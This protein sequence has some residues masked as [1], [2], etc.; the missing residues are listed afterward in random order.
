MP[1]SWSQLK[2]LRFCGLVGGL[3][4]QPYEFRAASDRARKHQARAWGLGLRSADVLLGGRR[5]STESTTAD[6]LRRRPWNAQVPLVEGSATL[7]AYEQWEQRLGPLGIQVPEAVQAGYKQ[8]QKE[9]AVR[10]SF[11]E[12]VS[13]DKPADAD[14]L[15]GFLAYLKLEEVRLPTLQSS[16]ASTISMRRY[17]Y[18]HV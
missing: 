18:F 14:K 15:A 13:P 9:V 11:E 3:V 7:R 5:L 2:P 10:A 4:M 16:L 12:A 17:S 1:F 8:A 6:P